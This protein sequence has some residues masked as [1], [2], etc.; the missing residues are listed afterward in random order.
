MSM[1]RAYT[2]TFAVRQRRLS[3]E[4]KMSLGGRLSFISPFPQTSYDAQWRRLKVVRPNP[5]AAMATNT[6]GMQHHRAAPLHPQSLFVLR[7][8]KSRGGGFGR[9]MKLLRRL[10]LATSAAVAF[11]LQPT[12]LAG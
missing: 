10:T 5:L 4:K 1:T 8:H 11:R 6:I 12:R 2:A 9:F 3:S 7:H